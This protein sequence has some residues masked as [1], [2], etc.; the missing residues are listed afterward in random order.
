M[1]TATQNQQT[2]NPSSL[3]GLVARHPMVAFLVMVYGLG[4]STLVAADYLGLPFLLVS[5]LGVVFGL[6]LPAF[7]VTAAT[8]GKAGVMDLAGR[9]LRWRVGIGWYLLASLGLLVATLLAATVFLGLAP[10]EALAQ[11]WPLLFT[12][13]LP[14]ILVPL[15]ITHLSEE[16]G[17]TGFMQDALQERRGPL[18]AS[19]M[20]APAFV[21]FHLPLSFLEAPQITLAVVQL[22]VVQLAVQAIVVIFFR[23][24]IMWLYNS[25]GRSVLIVAL[26]HSAFNSA[27]TGSEY[28]T[29]FIKELIP[30][31][32][33]LLI[34]LVVV[35]VV[36]V[37]V[38][39]FTRGR[40]A[41]EPKHAVRPA[42]RP[43]TVEPAA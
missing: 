27:G 2:P 24:V 5:S 39:L 36:A 35:A 43:P 30:R 40:L 12:M 22:A 19:I 42:P 6:A 13:F 7:L 26:F 9:C 18:L 32:A 1:S 4:W 11:K 16:A 20:V 8:S 33:A 10:L 41:Y 28:A 37:L 38:F 17:W 25:T 29:R 14:G 31:P 3:G 34:P 15:V 23:V 21:L